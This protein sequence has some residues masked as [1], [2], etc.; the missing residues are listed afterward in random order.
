LRYYILDNEPSLWHST[1]RDVRPTGATMD[2]VKN[3]ILDYGGKIK[4]I[5]PTALVAGQEEWGW[6]GYFFSG[7]DQQYGSLNGWS[8]LPDR[9]NHGGAEYLPWLLGQ[10]RQNDVATGARLLDVF[11]V[12][13]YPQSGEFSDDVSSAMQLRRNRST[14]SLWD[15]AY[16]DESWINDRVQLVPRL[17]NWVNT[18]YPGTLT[19][20]TEYNW[21]A[22]NHINGATAQADIFGI[23]G[24]E[25]LDM[26]ARWATPASSTPT[27]KAMK[28]YRNYDGN[29]SAFGETGI[30][31]TTPDADTVAA[32]AAQRSAD[33][34]L[35]AM[36]IS[37]YLSANTPATITLANFAHGPAA[38]VWQLTAANT[39]NPLPAIAL[40]GD[41]F[42][43]TLPPQ[44]ITLFV[45]AAN[46]KAPIPP[47]A[48]TNLRVTSN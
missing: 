48:P 10:L 1:H 35:T 41:S 8:F 6:S 4:Q 33:G 9:S 25:G 3:R 44:S 29:G 5:D 42:G 13:Y 31:A 7:Y 22:E 40:S 30:G 39:I 47:K 24:R 2:D 26:A 16:V 20:I 21:G 28:M 36:V 14:R 45:V 19:G 32:F 34:A 15:P 38:R 17:K 23:F 37:K 18:S 11:T 43:V 27:Y 46:S 12:H